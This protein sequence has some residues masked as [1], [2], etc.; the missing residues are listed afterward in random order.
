MGGSSVGKLASK[1]AANTGSFAKSSFVTPST[2]R[3][4]SAYVERNLVGSAALR[5]AARESNGDDAIVED[6][7]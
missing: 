5:R 3:D 4:G 2:Y 7:R 1:K 6:V